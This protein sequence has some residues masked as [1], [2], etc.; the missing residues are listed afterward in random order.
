MFSSV[1]ISEKQI[2]PLCLG[3]QFLQLNFY[4]T[5]PARFLKSQGTSG[6]WMTLVFILNIFSLQQQT[7]DSGRLTSCFCFNGC[8][9]NPTHNIFGYLGVFT[10]DV[11][12]YFNASIRQHLLFS[13]LEI[14]PLLS[15]AASVP[16]SSIIAACSALFQ[17]NI[18][19]FVVSPVENTSSY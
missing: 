8:D 5:F 13:V 14:I 2:L 9:I 1:K 3:N 12:N 18:H 4:N 6:I 19:L 7:A 16:P 17:V 15:E 11:I 10:W